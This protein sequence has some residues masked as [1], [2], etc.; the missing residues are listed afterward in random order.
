MLKDFI[1]E[2][3]K[4]LK[5]EMGQKAEQPVNMLLGKSFPSRTANP[6]RQGPRERV[7]LSS[8]QGPA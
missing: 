4:K 5:V 6:T 7:S 3:E 8:F 2:K 1:V